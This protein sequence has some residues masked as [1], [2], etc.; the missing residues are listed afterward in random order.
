MYQRIA[1]TNVGAVLAKPGIFTA[2]PF[3]TEGFPN[4]KV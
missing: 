4:R 2:F 1:K 3:W